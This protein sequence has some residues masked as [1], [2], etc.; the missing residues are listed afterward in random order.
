MLSIHFLNVSKCEPM[1]DY[2][3]TIEVNGKI[4]ATERVL[5]HQ[6]KDGWKGLV[7]K[8]ASAL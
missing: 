6:R 2:K 5:N 3:V 1:S 8:F 7:K 4:I